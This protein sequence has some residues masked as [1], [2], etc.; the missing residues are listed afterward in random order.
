M[1]PIGREPD[2]RGQL[3][4]L[5]D[6]ALAH[7][8][9]DALLS[10]LLVRTRDTL[11][12]D[13]SA[14]LLLD[15]KTNELVARAAVGIE[16]EVEQGVRVPVGKGF[17]GRIAATSQ[18]IILDDV[19]RADV[20]NPLLAQKG[21]H[22]ML[23]V[24]LVV[25]SQVLG[26]LHVGS[27]TPRTFD[28]SDVELLQLVADRAAIA[29]EHARLFEA[30]Q[31]ARRRIENVQAIT[32]TALAYLDVEELLDVLLPRIRD[33]LDADTCTVL[34][35]D[36]ETDELV[37]RAAIG[38]EEEVERGV[39]IP[40]GRGF[41]GVVA[42]DR[43]PVILDDVAKSDVLNPILREKGIHSM[44]GVPLVAAG[45]A[46]GVLHVGRLAEKP[47]RKDDIDLLQLAADRAA[48][49]IEHA[50]LFEA[51]RRART[52]IENV[53]A[54]TD[55]ALA[56]L[57][58][59]DLLQMLLPRIRDILSAD[60]CAV[61]LL[62]EEADELV[63]RAALGI[64]E[65]VEQGVRVPLGRGFAGRIAVSRHPVI[66]DDL[67]VADVWNPI[68]REKG[69]KSML[70]VP[71]LVRDRAI[72]VMHVGTLT[73]RRFSSDDTD[74]LQ[75]VAERVALAVERAQ[76][77]EETVRLDQLKLNFVAIASHELRTPATSVYGAFAT[78]VERGDELSEDVREQLL[79][80]GYE[81]ATRLRRLLEELLDLSRLDAHAIALDPRPIVLHSAL[82]QIVEQAVGHAD[83]ITLHVPLDL[84]VVVDPLVLDRV[85]S[86]LLI[87]ATRYGR[88]PIVVA[89]EHH[90]RHLRV[91]VE[92]QGVGV[93]EEL[94]SRL[95]ER[96]ARG[97][98]A[99][100]SGL[101]LAIA[102]SYARAH[103]G[104]LI[105]VP[106]G[107]GARFELIVPQQT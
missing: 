61:L 31:G 91:S 83:D 56:H 74:L 84:A 64:E 9:L 97:E 78:I 70:G 67:D 107:S 86:N 40:L 16:E 99:A 2:R 90:D 46:I 21:I 98:T 37:A 55:A 1:T 75:L 93:P 4:A 63:A 35:R 94:R 10:T 18:P 47:F 59:D 7:L 104:D 20:V 14:V 57:D 8:E 68:L 58:V 30:E 60:T 26:V 34:L 23:G 77:H 38:L 82:A 32:D 52:R 71:L 100:G 87:N 13:T 96:F 103:G 102:R 42:A 41:A 76:L 62:D 65:E 27:L 85:V 6:A 106:G 36:E 17:A 49:A 25:E 3:Q 22:S 53:Q 92:D 48:I 39:R 89:A 54:V 105:Y 101:G 50:R 24:P 12:V 81:Q 43:R 44:A 79:Q 19:A 88:P 80:V 45:E 66:L 33:I 29:I 73:Y 95:F 5:T 72:G 11:G 51:E 15:P 28:E 69:L